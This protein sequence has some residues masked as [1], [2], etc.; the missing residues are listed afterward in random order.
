MEDQ[1]KWLA[2]EIRLKS[3]QGL[4]PWSPSNYQDTYEASLGK[5]AIII[6]Y[7]DLSEGY[8]EEHPVYT[9]SFVNE[10]G[11]VFHSMNAF[12][13][14]QLSPDYDLLKDIYEFAHRS[15]MKIDETLRSMFE[16]INS[17]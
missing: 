16:D 10:R 6:T 11:D 1:Y 13:K 15:Y 17:K 8:C 3:Q 2:T 12:S 4:I 9:L 7:N 5:G 14:D